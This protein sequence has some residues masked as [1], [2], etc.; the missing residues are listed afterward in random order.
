VW[1]RRQEIPFQR[2]TTEPTPIERVKRIN[3]VVRSQGQEQEIGLPR[4]DPY[5]MDIDRGRNC[6]VCGEFVHMA[7]HCRN[8]R[9]RIRIGDGRRLEYG[10]RWGREGNFEQLDNLKEEENLESLN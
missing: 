9:G 8:R 6:Y 4:R 1:L 2:V 10:Q 3:T 5:A 7:Q